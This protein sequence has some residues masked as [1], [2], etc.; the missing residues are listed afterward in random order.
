MSVGQVHIYVRD[1]DL[2]GLGKGSHALKQL[3]ERLSWFA[4]EEGYSAFPKV[5]TLADALGVT[6]RAIQYGLRRLEEKKLI[7][8]AEEA[9]QHRP[10]IYKINVDDILGF[11]LTETGRNR[12][13]R[14]TA[15]G[16]ADHESPGVKSTSTGD[17]RGE[18]N[19]I[20]GCKERDPG[21]KR[22]SS[23]IEE[24]SLKES[25]QESSAREAG[26]GSPAGP[27]PACAVWQRNLAALAALPAW[28]LLR[29]AIPDHDDGETLTLAVEAPLIGF[30]ILAWAAEAA[31][32]ALGRRLACRVERW[33]EPGLIERGVIR[34]GVANNIAH[35]RQGQPVG[36][37]DAAWRLWCNHADEIEGLAAAPILVD[38]LPDD[39]DQNGLYLAVGNVNGAMALHEEAG[40]QAA[41]VLGVPIVPRIKFHLDLV[42]QARAAAYRPEGSRARG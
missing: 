9:R 37:D 23:S 6:P 14:E 19:V 29:R 40:T 20:Q 36:L 38:C 18:K 5:Q 26:G 31:R 2:R 15:A 4:D 30:G 8:V 12:L 41:K 13:E 33:V 22:T 1:R 16:G 34:A 42:L 7:E 3:L 32:T 10:R 27:P 17:S 25:N 24:E 28:P 39:L 21:V 35:R 11:P